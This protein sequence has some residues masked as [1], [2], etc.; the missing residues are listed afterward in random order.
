MSKAKEAKQKVMDFISAHPKATTI[1]A[2]LA[3]AAGVAVLG[4][5]AHTGGQLAFAPTTCETCGPLQTGNFP[6]DQIPASIYQLLLSL[7][8]QGT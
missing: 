1:G 4:G 6:I 7:F 2:G 3:V 5:W 8:G